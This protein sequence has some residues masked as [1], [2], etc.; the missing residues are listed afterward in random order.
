MNEISWTFQDYINTT[1]HI[2]IVYEQ[3]HL[4]SKVISRVKTISLTGWLKVANYYV[5]S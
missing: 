4:E 2:L 5:Y 1:Q 3:G